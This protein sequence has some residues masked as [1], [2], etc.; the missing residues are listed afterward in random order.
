MYPS[1]TTGSLETKRQHEQGFVQDPLENKITSEH[2]NQLQPPDALQQTTQHVKL[3]VVSHLCFLFFS[4]F[5][6]VATV[7]LALLLTQ[8]ELVPCTNNP[9]DIYIHMHT[10]MYIYI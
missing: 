8:K 7:S 9:H 5:S 2:T 6:F 3:K 10:Y 4:F 1:A